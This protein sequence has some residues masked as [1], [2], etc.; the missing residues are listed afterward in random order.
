VLDLSVV[1]VN[2][3]VRDLLRRCL[4]SIEAS[5]AQQLSI[6]SIVID[7]ASTDGSQEMLSR[8]FPTARLFYN[9]SNSGFAPACNQGLAASRGRYVLFLNAD[10]EVVADGLVTMVRRMDAHREWAVAGPRLVHADGTVQSSRRRF[11]T[12]LTGIFESTRLERAWPDNIWARRYR[13]VGSADDAEQEVDWVV[14]ACLLCRPEALRQVRGF[15]EGFFM[16]S[17]ELD[18]CRR[19]RDA[20]WRVGYLPEAVVLHHEGKSSEQAQTARHIR[21]NTS[22]VRYFRKH[23]GRAASSSLRALLLA[24]YV[25]QMAEEGLKWL[26]GHKRALRAER[27]RSYMQ[28]V[29]SGLRDESGAR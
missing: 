22:K 2:W 29:G 23:H 18:L 19:L 4:L 24:M 16:Y 25:F 10:T 27:I 5:A 8:D 7:N 17:E 6:E 12:L 21:F 9:S 15:D 3:N 1:V 13:M 11:P 28:V 20:G 26:A 14:G